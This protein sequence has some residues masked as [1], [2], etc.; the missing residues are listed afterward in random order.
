MKEIEFLIDMP[1]NDKWSHLVSSDLSELKQLM[2]RLGINPYRFHYGKNL[3]HYDIRESEFEKIVNS[4]SRIK[5]V[6]S[7][8]IVRFL[9]KYY[10]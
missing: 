2:N 7:K 4:D 5:I 6:S 9:R 3:P 1:G 10:K 8:E